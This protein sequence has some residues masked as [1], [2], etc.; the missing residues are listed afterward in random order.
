MSSISTL[1]GDDGTSAVLFNRRVPKT[2]LHFEACGTVDELNAA[3]GLARAQ[4]AT[5]LNA[6]I[7]RIQKELVYLMGE[8]VLLDED[9]ER[10]D[11]FKGK[12]ITAESTD[13]L[14]AFVH[15]GEMKLSFNDWVMPGGN[16]LSAALDFA[17]TVCR[18]AERRVLALREAQPALNPEIIR[19][20]NRLSDVCFVWAREAEISSPPNPV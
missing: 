20:L 16:P 13:R 12:Y 5:E 6:E 9:R 3:L 17:R 2:D 18:R 14:T 10:Y 1:T 8:L 19:Y 11:Q 15:A 4:S 7:L